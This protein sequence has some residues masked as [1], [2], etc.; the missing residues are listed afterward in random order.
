MDLTEHSKDLGRQAA[1]RAVAILGGPVA[2]ARVLDLPGHRYQTVQSWLKTQVP[3][4]YCPLI[5]SET[6]ARGE[7]VPCAEIRP[8]VRWDLVGAESHAQCLAHPEDHPE[9]T[10]HG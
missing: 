6:R 10:A 1:A 3:A 2:A 4:E 5:E 7:V 9:G 8:D